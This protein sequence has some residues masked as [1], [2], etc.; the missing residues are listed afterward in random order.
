MN[1]NL[2]LIA[3]FLIMNA[4][5]F[6]QFADN[7]VIAHRGAWKTLNL[8]ENSLA[9]LKQAIKLKCYGSEF[10]VRMTADDVLIINHDPHYHQLDI[11]KTSYAELL[12]LNLANGEKLP[13]LKEYLLAGSKKNKKTKLILEIKPSTISKERGQL[14]AGKVMQ[15]VQELGVQKKVVYISFDYDI[16]LKLIEIN[17]AIETQYLDGSKSPDEL[18]SA[19]ITGLDYHFSVFRNK[20]EWI[21]TAK[22]NKLVLNA[23]TVNLPEDMDFL[24]ENNFDLI[25]TDE[26]ELLFKKLKDTKK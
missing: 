5:I 18:K 9:S 23:W 15:L 6:A 13:T 14:I 7:P 26:L 24:L 17:L 19:G 25:T 21:Q 16:L 1:K 11:E 4:T 3:V 10:D 22:K 8:P 20:P 2:I 12:K